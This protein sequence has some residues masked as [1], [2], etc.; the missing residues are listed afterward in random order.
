[1]ELLLKG[2]RWHHNGENT[3][4][5]IRVYKGLISEIG[6]GL[7][8]KKGESI[9]QFDDYF[10]YPGL[11]NAHD[12]L[13]MN[14][15]PRLGTPPYRNYTEWGK[16]IYRPKES[17]IRDIEKVNIEDRLLW[18][19]IKNMITGATTVVHHNP[20]QKL[21]ESKH[22]P[23]RVLKKYAWSHS[24]VNGKDLL[25]SF[26]KDSSIP[27]IIHTA[28][29]VDELAFGEVSQLNSQ[30]LLKKNTVLIHAVGVSDS[31]ID[32]IAIEHA[33][34]VWCPASNYF[35]FDK[36]APIEKLKSRIKIALGSDS[37]LTGSPTL[38]SEMKFAANKEHAT[39]SEIFDWVTKTPAQIFNLPAPA[40]A[41]Q[42]PADFLITP[43]LVDDYF[44]NL[45]HV[46][47][48]H[49]EMVSVNGEPRFCS[50]IIA[51]ELN[52]KKYYAHVNG[53][54]KWFFTDVLDLKRRIKKKAGEAVEQNPL[55]SMIN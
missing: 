10:I 47:P 37:T 54:R 15:Y 52:F 24:L 48:E 20:W 36:T 40:I 21:L 38:L 11:I 4:G 28:E 5:D 26:P 7:A 33:S 3:E 6:N 16:D 35:L 49:I 23:V 25:K 8:S 17:P 12:H 27:F 53:N 43:L 9:L 32:L 31:D 46:T 2:L 51:H 42:G 50:D 34:V 1:M 30:K 44:E 45:I 29:G 39:A 13:E 55:W 18:G 19:G 22:F 14:L 41:I